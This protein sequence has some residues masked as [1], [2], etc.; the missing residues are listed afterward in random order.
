MDYISNKIMKQTRKLKRSKSLKVKIA[1]LALFGIIAVSSRFV[2]SRFDELTNVGLELTEEGASSGFKA[3]EIK[4]H[5]KPPSGLHLEELKDAQPL[6]KERTD[7]IYL[8]EEK[9]KRFEHSSFHKQTSTPH[10]QKNN[11]A[12]HVKKK[13]IN[14]Q[15]AHQEKLA[16]KE[17]SDSFHD[18][19]KG[20]NA[21]VANNEDTESLTLKDNVSYT[22]L[23]QKEH[24]NPNHV[25]EKGTN[26]NFAKKEYDDSHHIK[27]IG[28]SNQISQKEHSDPIH[29]HEKKVNTQLSQRE[30]I[31]SV[32]FKEKAMKKI[33]LWLPHVKWHG[34]TAAYENCLKRCP[35]K[36][37]M[38]TNKDDV[39]KVDAIDFH[40]SDVWGEFWKVGTR[41]M[42]KFPSYR[43]PDQVWIVSNLEPP[44]NLWGDLTI[45][46]GM[47][48]WTRWYRL[49]ATIPWTYGLSRP[50]TESGKEIAAN[51]TRGRNYFKEK[52]AGLSGR[53]TNCHSQSGRE[54]ILKEM[55]KRLSIDWQ[56]KCY[57]KP[58]GSFNKTSNETD[59]SCDNRLGS[60]RFFIAF[61]NS[62]C[63]DYVSEKYWLSISRLQI[64]L[65]NWKYDYSHLV[66]PKSYINVYDFHDVKSFIDHIQEVGRNETLYNSYFDWRK[67]H[68]NSGICSSCEI[69]KAL[70]DRRMVPHVI[71]DL[72]GWVRDDFKEC[73]KIEAPAKGHMTSK[74][75]IIKHKPDS[76]P[77]PPTDKRA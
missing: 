28:T 27:E 43:R 5:V 8:K 19:K 22:Q 66:L 9:Q 3:K 69:C 75:A 64:P 18:T 10:I 33:L 23:K 37:E 63:K 12:S 71:K 76:Q 16:Q 48:N 41:T 2:I 52:K 51:K 54:P 53:I 56:G 34:A 7:F 73:K 20:N 58:C 70:H 49:D 45:F 77:L 1:F 32:Y 15:L 46:N 44:C 62:F 47:F 14:T 13:Q 31:G 26:T 61:E 55:Q 39:P 21:K 30:N 57:G 59:E 35:I 24:A 72:D 4:R 50:L 40:L 68:A 74:T 67:T 60:Y 29:V 38:T 25:K 65:V 36:C 17:N 42:I 6:Q 11:D